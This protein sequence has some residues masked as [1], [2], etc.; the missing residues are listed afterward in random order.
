MT[1]KIWL[2]IPAAGIGRRMADAI[3]KQY[4]PLAGRS[5]IEWSLTPFLARADIAG[6]VV[7]LAEGDDRFAGLPVSRAARVQTTIGGS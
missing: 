6:V 2:V 7:V 3:P 1:D 5:V 4:L